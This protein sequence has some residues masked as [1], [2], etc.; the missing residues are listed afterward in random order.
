[1][2]RGNIAEHSSSRLLATSGGHVETLNGV[3]PITDRRTTLMPTVF[4]VVIDGLQSREQHEAIN[5]AIQRAVVA[6]VASLDLGRTHEQPAVLSRWLINGIVAVEGA[7]AIQAGLAEGPLPEPWRESQLGQFEVVLDG[8][9]LADQQQAAIQA[10]I[11]AAV[12][13]HIAALDF[14]DDRVAAAILHPPGWRGIIARP[15]DLKA[16]ELQGNTRA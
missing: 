12:L 7:K 15:Y 1:M 6:H 13:P 11:Q 10:G 9:E 5:S 14:G 2:P 16:L 4:K 3:A 8:V